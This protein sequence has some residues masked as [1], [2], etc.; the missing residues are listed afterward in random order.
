MQVQVFLSFFKSILLIPSAFYF[1][2]NFGISLSVATKRKVY[3]DFDGNWIKYVGLNL[4]RISVLMF[5]LL[6]RAYGVSVI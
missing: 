2:V 4:G 3:W 6:I 5:S 1:Q